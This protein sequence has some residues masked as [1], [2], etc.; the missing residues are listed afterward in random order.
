M[1]VLAEDEN[2]KPFYAH[3]IFW[4]CVVWV[5]MGVGIYQCINGPAKPQTFNEWLAKH[6]Q[7]CPQCGGDDS[8]GPPALCMEAFKKLQ[9]EMRNH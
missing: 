1:Y 8:N 3:L 4:G 7:T 2:G 5:L 6:E 9:E